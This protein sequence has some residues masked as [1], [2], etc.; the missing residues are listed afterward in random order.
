ME[1]EMNKKKNVIFIIIGIIIVI[2]LCIGAFFLGKSVVNKEENKQTEISDVIES[3]LPEN[4]TSSVLYTEDNIEKYEYFEQNHTSYFDTDNAKFI[5]TEDGKLLW[6]INNE[7][8]ADNTITDEVIIIDLEEHNGSGWF[9]GYIVTDKLNLYYISIDNVDAINVYQDV[10]ASLNIIPNKNIINIKKID[11]PYSIKHLRD[12]NENYIP[13]KYIVKVTSNN[14]LYYLIIDISN[15]LYSIN[16]KSIES[17]KKIKSYR[18]CDNIK[19]SYD[20]MNIEEIT[21]EDGEKIIF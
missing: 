14:E 21:F 5:K 11:F 16:E 4:V 6:N 18:R 13:I 12:E 2:A 1:K 20:D 3:I 10:N 7:W 8:V 15:N 19:I 9:T 17:N